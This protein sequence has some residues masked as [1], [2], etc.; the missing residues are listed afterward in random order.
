MTTD[1]G[2]T[3]SIEPSPGRMEGKKELKEEGK[4]A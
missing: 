2:V 1:D 4:R 3:R